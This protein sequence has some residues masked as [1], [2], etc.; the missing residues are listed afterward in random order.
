MEPLALNVTISQENGRNMLANFDVEKKIGKGQFS[1][2]YR[3]RSRPNGS[4][5]ALK[6]VQVLQNNLSCMLL[7]IHLFLNFDIFLLSS[8][9]VVYEKKF[10]CLA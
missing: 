1:E 8:L 2:V 3:A 5:V 4:V 6:K 9:F 10:S 7:I